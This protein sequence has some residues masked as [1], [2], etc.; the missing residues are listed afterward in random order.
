MKIKCDWCGKIIN[1]CPS[2]IKKHNFCSRKCLGH[3]SSKKD[4]PEGYQYR[5]FSKNSKR[6]TEMNRALNPERMTIET[7][8]KLRKSHLNTGK[9]ISY[10]KTFDKH[11]H[12][13]IAEEILGRPLKQ[14]E[15]VHHIDG[16]KRNNSP[17]NLMIFS[18]QSEHAKW[19]SS[20]SSKGGDDI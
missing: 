12:R 6:F 13:V 5:D 17:N 9:G 2:Q 16:N 15:V 20:H 7:K 14:G 10:E 11:T 4:N 8:L 1:R 19:H 3:F 18:S